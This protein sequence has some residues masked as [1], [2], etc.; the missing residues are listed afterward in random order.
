MTPAVHQLDR[1]AFLQVGMTGLSLPG[2]LRLRA[3]AGTTPSTER[4]A[5]IVCFCHGGV[6]HIDT[7]D[8]KPNAPAEYRGPFAPI[9][10]RVPGMQVSELLPRHAAIADKICLLRSLAHEAPCHASGPQELMTGHR[11]VKESWVTEHPD[12]L[13]ITNYLRWEP[14]RTIPNYIGLT[15]SPPYPGPVPALGPAYLGGMYEPFCVYNDPNQPGFNVGISETLESPRLPTRRGLMQTLSPSSGAAAAR[16]MDAFQHQALD[17]LSTDHARKAFD[18]ER[19]APALRDR[20]G[21]TGWGQQCLLARRLV[22][23]GVDLVT[24]TLSGSEAGGAGG[25]WDDH[26]VNCHI[27]EQ[28]KKRC[29]N[30]DRAVTALIEDLHDR[31]LDRRVMVVVTGEFGR[32]PR[33]SHAVGTLTKVSQPGRDHWPYAMSIL[34][35]GGGIRGGQIIGATDRFGE[36]PA[37]RR[38]GVRDFLATLYRHLGINAPNVAV[39]D[40]TG[41]PIP[42]LPEGEPIAEL[43]AAPA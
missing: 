40:Q 25:N 41:R 37:R 9:A 33:I 17:I 8:P 36:R 38:L 5:L 6:S 2:L 23:A 14:G 11:T 15:T 30:Y 32:T 13:A 39:K 20:Y 42:I 28:M 29:P 12:I 7:Y 18:L 34:F 16:K 1:R 24:V 31:G 35:A 27:F 3:E 43:V 4:T 22:E 21:R 19:E 26:A 10:T